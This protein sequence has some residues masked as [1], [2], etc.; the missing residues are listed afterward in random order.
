MRNALTI[1][2]LGL[3]IDPLLYYV[4]LAGLLSLA[5]RV[6]MAL[7]KVPERESGKA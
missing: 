6:V 1:D 2:L 5:V 4:L 3:T 7:L